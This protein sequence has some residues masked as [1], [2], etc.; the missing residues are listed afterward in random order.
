MSDPSNGTVKPVSSP[1]GTR[2]LLFA[3]FNGED[4]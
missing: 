1:D 4:A 3:E 2:V